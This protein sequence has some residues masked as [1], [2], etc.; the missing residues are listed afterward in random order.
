MPIMRLHF[1]T[2]R[3]PLPYEALASRATKVLEVCEKKNDIVTIL[4]KE[5]PLEENTDTF[6]GA[7]Q[8]AGYEILDAQFWLDEA[9]RY[10]KNKFDFIPEENAGRDYYPYY[11]TPD[12]AVSGAKDP[13][14]GYIC[15]K[16]RILK[17]KSQPLAI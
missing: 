6:L 16:I 11:Q 3:S 7:W 10:H 4:N 15:S 17:P 14:P 5:N 9:S 13:N 8:L 2:E 12:S 1:Q